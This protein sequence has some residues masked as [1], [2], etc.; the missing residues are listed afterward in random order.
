MYMLAIVLVHTS[1][2]INVCTYVLLMNQYVLCMYVPV[3]AMYVPMSYVC[4]SMCYEY[5]KYVL[6]AMYIPVCTMCSMCTHVQC[7]YQYV[8]QFAVC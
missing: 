4:T 6:C 3:C 2:C 7:M 1:V 5:A 8:Y